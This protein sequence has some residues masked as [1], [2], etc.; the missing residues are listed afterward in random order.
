MVKGTQLA[1]PLPSVSG[2]LAVILAGR[3]LNGQVFFGGPP[4]ENSTEMQTI[5]LSKLNIRFI[6]GTAIDYP[7]GQP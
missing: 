4:A 1:T 2:P 7:L 3:Q 5:H 6:H